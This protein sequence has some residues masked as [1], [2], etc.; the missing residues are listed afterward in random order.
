ME[1]KSCCLC[2]VRRGTKP[3]PNGLVCST[4]LSYSYY[5]CE[6]PHAEGRMYMRRSE[7]STYTTMCGLIICSACA[8]DPGFKERMKAR[9]NFRGSDAAK[10]FG[11]MG[12]PDNDLYM[13]VELETSDS[14][15]GGSLAKIFETTGDFALVKSEGVNSGYG[16]EI[17]SAPMS[18]ELHKEKWEPF[19]NDIP[20]TLR[21]GVEF[22]CGMHI[23]VSRKPL[24]HLRVGK[25]AV[26]INNAGNRKFNEA[27]AG[28]T[29]SSYY[30]YHSEVKLDN[31][32][33][34][35]DTKGAAL[36]VFETSTIEFRIFTGVLDKALFCK[37]IEF[38]HALVTWSE[39]ADQN[40]LTHT[41]FLQWFESSA[42]KTK[43]S[44][45]YSFFIEKKY[46]A[47]PAQM[48]LELTPKR[49]Y[50]SRK[51]LVAVAA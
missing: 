44:N 15:D 6:A 40:D 35:G 8:S 21:T 28:R 19:F 37:N 20:A 24:S 5:Y 41:T 36:N 4:C 34:F 32:Q 18:F 33:G 9:L 47:D 38:V 42:D 10:L 22:G 3:T 2:S 12:K 17:V 46:L 16:I 51:A 48:K 29:N 50:T 27:V 49:K 23:H 45:L 26:F 25:L 11:F 43:Y 39:G 31:Y 30:R 13:G 14:T 7:N 1:T